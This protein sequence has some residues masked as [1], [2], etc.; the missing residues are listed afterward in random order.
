V[1]SR[2][3][4]IR[5]R[6]VYKITTAEQ[7]AQA[8]RVG[9]FTGSPDDVRDGFIHLSEA[10]QVAGTAERHFGRM[11]GLVLVALDAE[12][13]ADGLKWEPSRSGELFPHYYGTLPVA[14]A[15][16]V[17]SLSL[18]PDG[19]PQVPGDLAPC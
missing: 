19:V 5:A 15:C 10:A 6:L 2:R 3:P 1:N 18:G 8:C 4:G 9:A 7:W 16:W 17:R 11:D 12:M 13:L 14:A